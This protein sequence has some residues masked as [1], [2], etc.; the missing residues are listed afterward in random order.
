MAHVSCRQYAHRKRSW[1]TGIAYTTCYPH[2]KTLGK[3]LSQEV[4][5]CRPLPR[6]TP[7]TPPAAHRDETGRACRASLTG[8]PATFTRC[9]RPLTPSTGRHQLSNTR[10]RV[11]FLQAKAQTASASQTGECMCR[12]RCSL[13]LCGLGSPIAQL[14]MAVKTNVSVVT[15][16]MATDS[17]APPGPSA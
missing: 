10:C 16:G 8:A 9:L 5:P 4:D 3:A 17:S 13:L 7:W 6:S 14:V 12:L 15:T 1:W 2:R 11:Q